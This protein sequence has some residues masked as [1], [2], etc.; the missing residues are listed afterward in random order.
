LKSV[1]NQYQKHLEDRRQAIKYLTM[2]VGFVVFAWIVG[3]I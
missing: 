1:F 3:I 2:V